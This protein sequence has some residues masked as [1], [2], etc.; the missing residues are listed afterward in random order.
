[1]VAAVGVTRFA[2]KKK[3]FCQVITSIWAAT[4][5]GLPLVQHE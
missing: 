3:D 4:A 5:K 2:Q 1:M